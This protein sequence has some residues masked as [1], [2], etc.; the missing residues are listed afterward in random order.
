MLDQDP[1]KKASKY[2]E[3]MYMNLGSPSASFPLSTHS[4]ERQNPTTDDRQPY[5]NPPS[6]LHLP[7]PK[8]PPRIPH[9]MSDPIPTMIRKRQTHQPLHQPLTQSRKPPKPLRHRRA[10]QVPPYHRTDQICS[11]EDVEASGQNAGGDTV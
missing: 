7:I 4:N 6:N 10:L 2:A 3:S 11:A 5:R 9:Q 1:S 8:L